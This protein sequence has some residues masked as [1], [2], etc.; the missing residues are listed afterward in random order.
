MMDGLARVLGYIVMVLVAAALL[1]VVLISLNE[2]VSGNSNDRKCL[3]LAE[4]TGGT[5]THFYEWG[6]CE[7]EWEGFYVTGEGI[8]RR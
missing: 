3:E 2:L 6:D 1:V 5:V 7:V 4:A 8:N